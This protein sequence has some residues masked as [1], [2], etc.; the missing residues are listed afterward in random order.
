MKKVLC[1]KN[2]IGGNETGT[3]YF[4]K[5]NYYDCDDRKLLIFDYNNRNSHLFPISVFMRYFYTEQEI[6]KQKLE[7]INENR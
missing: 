4:K 3:L 5:N 2:F 6:R 7:K 1:K